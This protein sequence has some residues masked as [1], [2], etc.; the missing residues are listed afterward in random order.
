MVAAWSVVPVSRVLAQGR[1]LGALWG[2]GGPDLRGWPSRGR[3]RVAGPNLPWAGPGEVRR[4]VAR[5]GSARCRF[6]RPARSV[7]AGV[8]KRQPST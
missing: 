4:S 7:E 2:I 5:A 8:V 1:H 6:A 3:A